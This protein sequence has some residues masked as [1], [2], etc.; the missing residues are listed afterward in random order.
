MFGS[1]PSI[2]PN[3]KYKF[4]AEFGDVNMPV[5]LEAVVLVHKEDICSYLSVI[6]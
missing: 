1:P 3:L 6:Y 5:S 2:L 4:F